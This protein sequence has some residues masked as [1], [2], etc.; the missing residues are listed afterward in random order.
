VL[1]KTIRERLLAK[2]KEVKDELRKR[3]KS[4]VQG[5]FKPH[6]AIVGSDKHEEKHPEG[7]YYLA[8]PANQRC[9]PAPAGCGVPANDPTGS[10]TADHGRKKIHCLLLL[11][12]TRIDAKV[13]IPKNRTDAS[14]GAES[15]QQKQRAEKTAEN[16]LV[17]GRTALADLM[18]RPH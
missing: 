11:D 13:E 18:L 5:Y 10:A 12:G 14:R 17:P 6:A 16:P 9:T 8:S 3:L 7:A 15:Q 1:R 2:L 4:V